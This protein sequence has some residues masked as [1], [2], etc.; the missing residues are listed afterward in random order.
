MMDIW[1]VGKENGL[2][3]IGSRIL[4]GVQKGESSTVE[5]KTPSSQ[6]SGD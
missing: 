5:G 1:T 3:G 2:R 4:C 6:V